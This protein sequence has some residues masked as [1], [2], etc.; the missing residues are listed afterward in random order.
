MTAESSCKISILDAA[1]VAGCWLITFLPACKVRY[2]LYV[3]EEILLV[4][5]QSKKNVLLSSFSAAHSVQRSVKEAEIKN[6]KP[7]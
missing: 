6:I 3:T 7:Q 1:I 4:S 5:D 2:N